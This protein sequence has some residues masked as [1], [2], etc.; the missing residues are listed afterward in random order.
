MNKLEKLRWAAVTLRDSLSDIDSVS[1]ILNEL[2][3]A[4][5]ENKPRWG[6]ESDCPWGLLKYEEQS[7]PKEYIRVL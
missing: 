6:S 3:E 5:L 7:K 1:E 4:T 2:A